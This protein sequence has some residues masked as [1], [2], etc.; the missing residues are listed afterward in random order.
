MKIK[1]FKHNSL[2]G[3]KFKHSTKGRL[4]GRDELYSKNMWFYKTNPKADLR[5]NR[6]VSA[7]LLEDNIY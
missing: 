1:E 7:Y 3:S 2:A 5:H 4:I 6:G